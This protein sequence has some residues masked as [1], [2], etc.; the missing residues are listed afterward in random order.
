MIKMLSFG[1]RLK[2][3]RCEADLSQSELADAIGA[4][5]QSVSRWE[6]DSNMP[7]ISLL[8]PL[9]AV[10]GVTADCLL[11]AGTNE[12]EDLEEL[13][14]TIFDMKIGKKS[15]DEN[16]LFY[17][18]Y[19]TQKEFLKKYP[20]NYAVKL[21]CADYLYRNLYWRTASGR[22]SV[23]D[24][25]FTALWNEGLKL[26]QSVKKQDTD[27]SRQ[28]FARHILINYYSMIED[29]DRAEEAANELPDHLFTKI[30]ALCTVACN[31]KDFKRAEELAVHRARSETLNSV[32]ALKLRARRISIFG[33]ARKAEAIAAWDD[34]LKAAIEFKRLFGDTWPWELREQIDLSHPLTLIS[35]I[36]ICKHCDHIAI[37][38][39]DDALECIEQETENTIAL[40]K[41][42]CGNV[43]RDEDKFINMLE[44]VKSYPEAWYNRLFENDDNILTREERFKAC[45]ARIDALE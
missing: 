19:Q 22:L 44:F 17:N 28:S 41:E 2:M 3:L 13:K 39:M 25:E 26:I 43:S 9:S 35:E 30:D 18:I 10:L 31:K 14:K 29:W 27:P 42:L 38:E 37:G 34:A 6:C 11:G 32:F 1:Q 4:S 23:S 33:N 20:M 16:G 15:D 8:L 5:V 24:E 36:L 21:E 40:Y 7:D 12:K 45:K